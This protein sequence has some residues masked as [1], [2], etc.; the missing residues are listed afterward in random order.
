[1][2]RPS[3][4]LFALLAGPFAS[5]CLWA[6]DASLDLFY[7]QYA[8][9]DTAA[10]VGK[11]HVEYGF[12]A[13]SLVLSGNTTLYAG[14][15][16]FGAAGLLVDPNSSNLLIA[17]GGT[18]QGGGAVY[19]ITQNGSPGSPFSVVP[20]TVDPA[21]GPRAYG[22]TI[23]P[24]TGGK[25]GFP[26][27]YLVATEK[28]LGYGRI[29][30]LPLIPGLAAG[31]SYPVTGDDVFVTSIA[32]TPDG[33]AYYGA[34]TEESDAGNFGLITFNGAQFT[35][36]RL[37]GQ[38]VGSDVRG[39]IIYAGTHG[40]TFDTLTGDIFTAG[41][42]GVGQY[43]PRTHSFHV[44]AISSTLNGY[45]F[46]APFNDGQ[47][48]VLL[49]ACCGGTGSNLNGAGDLVVVDYSAAPGN[50][51]DAASGV[52]YR[53]AFLATNFGGVT[54]SS[55]PPPPPGPPV[56]TQQPQN[57][58]AIVGETAAFQVAAAGSGNT[59]QWQSKPSGAAGFTPINGATGSTY[60]TPAVATT[61]GGT[62]FN[63]V[64]TNAQG[65]TTSSAAT[66]T[67]L[68]SSTKFITSVQTG[69][70]RNNYS[71]W[72]GTSVS[73]GNLPLTVTALGRMF[74]SGNTHGHA[75]KIVNASTGSD[76]AGTSVTVS[77]A[78]GVPGAFAYADLPASVTMSAN[79]TYY[80]LTQESAGGDQWYDLNTSAQSTTVASL[81]GAE[82]GLPYV[83][84]Q[85]TSGHMYGPVDFKYALTISVTVTPSP[86]T[87]SVSDS[88][89]FNATVTGTGITTVNWSINPTVGT[90]VGGLYNAPST[91]STN[92][93]ITVTAT[94]TADNSKFGT[95]TVNLVAPSLPSITS[96][97]QSATV[98]AGQTATFNVGAS[99]GALTY[100]WQSKAPGA[101]S[102][103]PIGGATSN[104]Y[105][106]LP[107]AA[108]DSGTQFQCV[109][110]N[111]QG[112][113]NSNVVVLTVV[114]DTPFVT[115]A[116][117]GTQRN[118]YSG[119]VGM[120]I[121]IN[122]APITVTGLGR[123][124]VPG[125]TSSHTVKI[126]NALSGS[127]VSGGSTLVALSG[128]SGTYSY[129]T[130]N[131]P[132]VLNAN[133]T[134]Y[135]LSQETA[136]GDR[137]YDLNTTLQGSAVA[138]IAGPVYSW[139]TG[140]VA[141]N[142]PGHSYVPVDFRYTPSAPSSSSSWVSSITTGTVRN[143]FSGWVGASFTTGASPLTLTQLG[144]LFVSGNS[145]THTVKVVT[146]SGVQ[147]PGASASVNLSGGVP[148]A[149]NYAAVSPGVTLSPNTTYFIVSQEVGAGDQ[150][151][152]VNTQVQTSP[153]ATVNGGIYSYDGASYLFISAPQRM[154]VPLD[155]KYQ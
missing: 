10:A 124:V 123:M 118:D 71:G 136:G 77:P 83:L 128:P 155:F 57:I 82:Y 61:D 62:Q 92:Q 88:Q 15:P 64:V 146:T 81:V 3:R 101:A 102:F 38:P 5:T 76:V 6:S 11:V 152:D 126:V 141:V 132:V 35:T 78:N 104:S 108:A 13:N 40:L 29:S 147:V 19:Q 58:S 86:V 153:A 69:T 151:Y 56:I 121:T 129:A 98:A 95:A 72:V 84:V 99:G 150:W 8:Y 59:Y 28:D 109:V 68:P 145:G 16:G 51:I 87:L 85:G 53:G 110:T 63:C 105:T 134:Y 20:D 31:T 9:G 22:L 89:Q 48:H 80:I 65:P 12:A 125:N 122:N 127:D 114:T 21:A 96:Q 117:P 93:A 42:N 44:L 74:V 73:V 32:F 111:G 4:I 25:S 18:V 43:D 148:G 50:L 97:P 49:V 103:V 47:G 39:G 2:L 144:R 14:G 27:N 24:A 149:F 131:N 154:Y 91:I 106:T 116:V 112:P 135:I 140:Y 143:D 41:G 100:Q 113:T 60:V 66:L 115:S 75:M 90:I 67:V 79:T 70:L 130:L 45:Q 142:S 17:G 137:W 46:T 33:T 36:F 1:M 120:S 119:W 26:P 52:Q 37:Y 34:G 94:S 7:T 107:V 30:F 138:T 55:G 133:T 23:V 139:Q 54:I